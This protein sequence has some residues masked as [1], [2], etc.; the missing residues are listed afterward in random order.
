[1]KRKYSEC[2]IDYPG[3]GIIT[4]EQVAKLVKEHTHW[5]ERFDWH[6]VSDCALSAQLILMGVIGKEELPDREKWYF[7]DK[8][9][10]IFN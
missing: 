9:C 7:T 1:M 3:V 10:Y 5:W 6:R 4:D 2:N 8:D